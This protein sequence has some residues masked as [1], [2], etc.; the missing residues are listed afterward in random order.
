MTSVVSVLALGIEVSTAATPAH[1]PHG[2]EMGRGERL[3]SR[4]RVLRRDAVVSLDTIRAP[5]H[6]A[7]MWESDQINVRSELV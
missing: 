5:A 3:V 6:A 4:P 2:G 7:P 1:S